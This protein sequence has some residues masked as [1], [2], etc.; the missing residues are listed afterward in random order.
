MDEKM[1]SQKT[2]SLSKGKLLIGAG[3]VLIIALLTII[4]VLL[5]G[6]KKLDE[7]KRNVVVNQQNAEEIA[8]EMISQEYVEPGYYS[9]SMTTT[10]NFKTGD[11]IS[12]DAYVANDME[13]TNDVYFDIFL[14]ENE[15]TPIFQ[16]PVIPRGSELG[17]IKLDQELNAGTY[18]CVMIYHLIDDEQ[19][20]IS[21]LR[22]GLTIVVEE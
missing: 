19:N 18:E 3:I 11:A 4:I 6:N 12:E 20:T 14:A 1:S 17:D 13:N 8:G 21:T 10:W 16:S 15:D 9:V 22:V 5:L 2:T 7:P